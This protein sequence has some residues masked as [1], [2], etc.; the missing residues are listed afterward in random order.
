LSKR[1]FYEKEYKIEILYLSIKDHHD[2]E[3]EI[4]MKQVKFL[5]T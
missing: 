1:G 2:P 4:G 3:K 5:K